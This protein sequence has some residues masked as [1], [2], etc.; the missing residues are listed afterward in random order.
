MSKEHRYL[1]TEEEFFKIVDLSSSLGLAVEKIIL[2][3]KLP[4]VF[5]WKHPA[6]VGYEELIKAELDRKDPVP[7]ID[8]VF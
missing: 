5:D 3:S 7:D 6:I 2:N 1:L 4:K 8:Q